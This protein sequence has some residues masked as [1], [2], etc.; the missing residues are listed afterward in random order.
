MNTTFPRKYP[1]V[2]PTLLH[3]DAQPTLALKGKNEPVI[4]MVLGWTGSWALGGRG[5]NHRKVITF[6]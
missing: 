2:C 3:V 5:N 6:F 4:R 1:A